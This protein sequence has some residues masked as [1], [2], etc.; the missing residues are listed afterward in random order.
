MKKALVAIAI[1]LIATLLTVAAF[2]TPTTSSTTPTN[3][4]TE[5]DHTWEMAISKDHHSFCCTICSAT[6]EIEAHTFNENMCIEC[7]YVAP[8]KCAISRATEN[9]HRFDCEECEN[10]TR[11]NHDEDTMDVRN[12]NE[13][14]HVWECNDCGYE[15]AEQHNFDTA[16]NATSHSEVCV[17]CG[18]VAYTEPH[19]M[20]NA[21]FSH[22]HTLECAECV[23]VS[24]QHIGVKYTAVDATGCR[25][26]CSCGVV[27]VVS[28]DWDG[29]A[30]ENC[31]YVMSGPTYGI[32]LSISQTDEEEFRVRFMVNGERHTVELYSLPDF[33][34]GDFVRVSHVGND[35]WDVTI[36][37][38]GNIAY[39]EEN[40]SIYLSEEVANNSLMQIHT[41]FESLVI[42]TLEY[43]GE[44]YHIT[45]EDEG[46]MDLL[47]SSC[48][49]YDVM[50]VG[51]GELT[52][53]YAYIFFATEAAVYCICFW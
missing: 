5:C 11:V 13:Y 17:D 26:T 30:C 51:M 34:E 52:E 15:Y 39:A 23:Y 40:Y 12:K 38:D 53:D 33:D 19:N 21:F 32:V 14:F 6:K 47:A 24:E 3:P 16:F 4:N 22:Y 37:I 42:E 44:V 45:F 36:L 28:H 50:D 48:I 49:I 41:S 9:Y 31:N 29:F 7:G 46:T 43:D 20:E 35:I 1:A 27:E 18:Y 8:H 2:A 25:A 10:Y